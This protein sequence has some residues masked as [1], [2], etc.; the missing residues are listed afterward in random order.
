MRR[1]KEEQFPANRHFFTAVKDLERSPTA[2]EMSVTS[3][4]EH[5]IQVHLHASSYAF[6]VHIGIAAEQTHFS[7]NY[8]DMNA[9]EKR[10]IV[11]SNPARTITPEML[12]IAW[13]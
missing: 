8:F 6:F 2:L 7:D 11:I 13:R 4:G 3:Q 1:S 10:T 5:E 9:G 12:S